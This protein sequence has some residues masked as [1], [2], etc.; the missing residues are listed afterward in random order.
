MNI[1][2]SKLRHWRSIW[3][4][5]VDCDMGIWHTDPMSDAVIRARAA[6]D[7]AEAAVE[8]RRE[9]LAAAI[10]EEVR[11]GAKLSHVA[12]KAK[13]TREHVRRIARAHGVESA[14]DREPPPG[15][16]RQPASP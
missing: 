15:R 10:A 8:R 1:P 4:A 7:R 5:H 2:S 14:I 9:E 13:Y 11:D 12:A 16:I 3:A 6:L